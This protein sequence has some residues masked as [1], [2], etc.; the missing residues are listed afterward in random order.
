MIY[1]SA[2]ERIIEYLELPQEPPLI[3]ETNRP[4]AYWPSSSD[5]ESLVDVKDLVVVR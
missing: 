3:I 1:T 5:N 4:P 2:A